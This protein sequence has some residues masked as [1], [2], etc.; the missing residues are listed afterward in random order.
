VFVPNETNNHYVFEMNSD[1]LKETLLSL[2]ECYLLK[3][4][5]FVQGMPHTFVGCGYNGYG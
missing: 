3:W 5:N 4:K 2:R 1:S